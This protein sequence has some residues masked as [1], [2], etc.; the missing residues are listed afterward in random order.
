MGKNTKS[1]LDSNHED[2]S[3]IDAK[4]KNVVVIG[5]GDTGNDCVGTAIRQ[6]AASVVQLEI[7]PEPPEKR[8]PGNAW[9]EWPRIKKTDYGQ[10]EAIEVF[11]SDP[12]LYETTAVSIDGDKNGC[13]KAVNITKV[14]K[15]A[16]IAGT[17]STLKADLVLIAMGFVGADDKLLKSFGVEMTNRGAAAADTEDHKTSVEGVFAAGDCR[18]GQSLVVRAIREGRDAAFSVDK[19]LSDF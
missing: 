3:Y 14:K 8:A 17:E 18:R 2:G 7:M 12:R 13:V 10:E 9:P 19:Y 15:F 11:G 1:L 6:G 16:P 5:G 4:G